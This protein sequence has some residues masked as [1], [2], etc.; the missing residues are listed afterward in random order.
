VEQ[1]IVDQL[2]DGELEWDNWS[3]VKFS[4]RLWLAG[5]KS[6]DVAATACQ[7]QIGVPFVK[8]VMRSYGLYDPARGMH[9]YPS[10]GW[11]TITRPRG[12]VPPP[13]P[14]TDVERIRVNDY[15]LGSTARASD[16]W[17]WVPASAAALT[18][19]MLALMGNKFA[20]APANA[21]G[22]KACKTLRNNLSDERGIALG[23]YLAGAVKSMPHVAVTNTFDKLGG[24][25]PADGVRDNLICEF[26]FL[27]TTQ[28]PVPAHGRNAMKYAVIALGL[29]KGTNPGAVD[30]AKMAENLGKRVHNA[31]LTL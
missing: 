20:D 14:L 29:I 1:A 21:E 31:L 8:S 3:D 25:G 5:A 15:W 30:G 23:S 11:S 22:T 12:G 16:Q 27:E 17:S 9:L 4:E 10:F 28:H 2:S 6:D 19:F 13:R 26:V 18:A 24:L 7:S